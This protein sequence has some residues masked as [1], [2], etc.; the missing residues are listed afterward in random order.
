MSEQ[1][2]EQHL[3]AI[4]NA[5]EAGAVAFF[6]LDGTLI[7]GYSILALALETARAGLGRGELRQ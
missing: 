2:L 1:A 5:S 7:A 3:E 6:D 4:G